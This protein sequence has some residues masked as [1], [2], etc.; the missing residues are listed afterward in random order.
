[1][2]K[3]K[4]LIIDD[5]EGFTQMVKL[6]LEAIDRYEVR[7]ENKATL[8]LTA[9]KA[10]KPDLILLDII[11][12]DMQGSEVAERLK[13]DN[14]TKAIPIVFLTAV[15][16]REETEASDGVIAGHSFLA[17]PVELKDLI[18]CIEKNINK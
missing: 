15:I 3:K 9:A 7:I 17:K 5:E 4:V 13:E 11:M 14:S 18:D 8:G 12:P 16:T 1:M 10:F 6:N 2:E